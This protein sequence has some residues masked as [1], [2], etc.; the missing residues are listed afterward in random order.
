[1]AQY[2]RCDGLQNTGDNR[3]FQA[4]ELAAPVL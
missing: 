3:R 4:G 2:E 1:M